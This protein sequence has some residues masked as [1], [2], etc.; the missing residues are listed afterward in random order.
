MHVITLYILLR[1]SESYVDIRVII[2]L[3]VNSEHFDRIIV[4]HTCCA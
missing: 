1:Y 3:I 2:T 4:D